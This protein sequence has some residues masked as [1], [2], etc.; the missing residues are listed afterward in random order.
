MNT[1][2]IDPKL[3]EAL[4]RA[5]SL[6]LYEL[7]TIIDRLLADPRRII[8]VRADL[9]MGQSVRFMDWRDGRMRSGRVMAMGDAKVTVHEDSTRMQWKLPYAAIEPPTEPGR[10]AQAP[11]PAPQAP[12]PK[13]TKAD[14]RRGDKV[15]FEDKYLQAQVGTILRINQQT[16]TIDTGDGMSWRVAFPLLRHVV[17]I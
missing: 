16:A 5:S 1:A 3:M 12:P 7:G 6:E 11:S 10:A 4:N 17:D 13:P 14:F 15:S 9:H 2:S 8:A